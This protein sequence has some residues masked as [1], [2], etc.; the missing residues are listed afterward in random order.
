MPSKY[1]QRKFQSGHFYHIFNRG[2]HKQD[3][4]LDR[5]DNQTFIRTL[6]H[7]LNDPTGLAPHYHKRIYKPGSHTV[8]GVP[9]SYK[10]T[11]LIAYCLMPN[12]FHLLLKQLSPRAQDGITNLMRRVSIAY[13][14]YFNDKYDRSGNLYQGKYK[15]VHIES[16]EQ[17]LNLSK[18]IHLNPKSPLKHSYSSLSAFIIKS[19]SP[20]W[21]RPEEV[22][23]L[24]YYKN[25]KN[26][27][28]D[29]QN[30][31]LDSKPIPESISS[32]T[33]E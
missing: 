21:L 27:Q 13:S 18:Y 30:F 4:F 31:V 10:T 32:L 16:N 25:S 17:L 3:V 9:N 8:N 20:K 15:Q 33:L 26:P 23:E 7:Y 11:I 28:K 1:Y 6:A 24:D 19:P 5:Q 29:Y 2:S 12:H 22:L 14:M